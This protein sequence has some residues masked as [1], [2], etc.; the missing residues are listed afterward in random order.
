[1]DESIVYRDQTSG[2]IYRKWQGDCARAVFLLVHGLGAYSR[3]W[4]D[5]V[6]FFLPYGISSYAI[7]LKGFGETKSVRGH[8]DS[9]QVYYHDIKTLRD[10]IEK[11]H[12]GK[13]IFVVGESLGGLIVFTLASFSPR[14]FNGLIC[15]SPAFK[16]RLNFN[17]FDYIKI[18]FFL[19]F[20][21]KKQFKMPFTEAMCTSDEDYQ[22]RIKDD[23]NEHRLASSRLLFST[24]L[25]QIRARILKPNIKMPVLFLVPGHDEITDSSA[26][27][28]IFKKLPSLDKRIIYYAGMAHALSIEKQ[29]EKVFEDILEWVD[30]RMQIK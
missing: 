6:R 12:S 9:F 11:E 5:L 22:K 7:D 8:I 29:R 16:N 21:P 25:A 23:K 3:R 18:F 19:L 20:N 15:I 27:E 1:M 17:L 24:L 30:K 13:K 4:D 14:L 28:R 26:T 2:I 10:I